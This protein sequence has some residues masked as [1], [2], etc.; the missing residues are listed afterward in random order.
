MKTFLI[1]L[2]IICCLFCATYAHAQ[3]VSSLYTA[4]VIG[5]N[6]DNERSLKIALTQVLIKLTGDY[7]LPST[8]GVQSQLKDVKQ[9]VTHSEVQTRKTDSQSILM[10]DFDPVK[11]NQ[12]LQKF[13]LTRWDDKRPDWLAWIILDTGD[14][15]IIVNSEETLTEANL[16]LDQ[17]QERGL[18]VFLPLLDLEE[19]AKL[20]I[21]DFI[22]ADRTVI[23]TVSQRYEPE[24][25]FVGH[26]TQQADTWQATWNLYMEQPVKPWTNNHSELSTLLTIGINKAVNIISAQS[27]QLAAVKET[28]APQPNVVVTNPIPTM[29]T[30]PVVTTLPPSVT[31][32]AV[33]PITPSSVPISPTEVP[34]PKI[35][36]DKEFELTVVNVP[37]LTAYTTV[38]N[39]LRSLE[40][41][42]DTVFVQS[43]Q[44]DQ[45]S[46]RIIPKQGVTTL[47]Q[48]LS[49][50][51]ILV[52]QSI[53]TD[54]IV[55]RLQ[56]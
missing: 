25:I 8:F 39:Y 45:V 28:I 3:T 11:V 2:T 12:L 22:K 1:N 56:Q 33:Q 14:K 43:V 24:V 46:F 37:N 23:T 17:A 31:A 35:I 29:S 40:E 50:S 44:S 34:Q 51:G 30:T 36:G 21:E 26:I 48:T 19:R 52:P 27:L 38:Y 7:K 18:P 15:P 42:I 55:Y 5:D 6:T 20:P 10:V 41:Q 32:T 54:E 53:F 9:L 13:R 49:N 4:Q 47:E 16:V